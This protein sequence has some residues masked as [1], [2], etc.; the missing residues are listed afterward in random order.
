MSAFDYRLVP[1]ARPE[2]ERAY[3]VAW[4]LGH[5][6][7][8]GAAVG[9]LVACGYLLVP[10]AWISKWLGLTGGWLLL[11]V[12][13][14]ALS[15]WVRRLAWR[16]PQWADWACLAG[17]ALAW[18]VMLMPPLR[19]ASAHLVVWPALFCVGW[20]VTEALPAVLSAHTR[21]G[22]AALEALAHV[23]ALPWDGLRLA[24]RVFRPGD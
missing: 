12:A 8:T 3:F 2:Q 13:L 23:G 1:A 22:P 11:L 7:T 20:R 4:L 15:A 14:V 6:A 9:L 5:V 16:V 21:P 18:A 10:R 17:Y 24:W 19:Q